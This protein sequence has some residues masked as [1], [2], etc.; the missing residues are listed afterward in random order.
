MKKFISNTVFFIFILI[1]V[2]VYKSIFGDANSLVGIAT[3]VCLLVLMK[4][5]LI[6][7]P[8]YNLNCLLALFLSLGILSYL[9]NL[10]IYLE[11]LCSF[12]AL[13][14]IG[15][16][17]TY[18]L[19]KNLIVPAGLLYL[20]L[21]FDPVSGKDLALRAAGLVIAPFLIMGFQYLIYR[22]KL[23]L[24][25]EE[26]SLLFYI[27]PNR[28][29]TKEYT[30]FGLHLHLHPTRLAFSLRIGV[31]SAITSLFQRLL[32]DHY[33]I[34][35]G[36]WLVYTIFSL[37]ELYSQ[38]CHIKSKQR[39]VGTLI[40]SVIIF[41]LFSIF[42]APSTRSLICLLVGYLNT[43]I[44]NYRDSSILVTISA[45]ATTTLT[46]DPGLVIFYRI[47]FVCIGTLIALIGDHLLFPQKEP[48]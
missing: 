12:I 14:S 1:F 23:L 43:Y 41:V 13:S 8:L 37:T 15:Y 38:N 20:F 25:T 27:R 28:D 48:A 17:L 4:T 9:A 26:S 35:E 46:S 7:K 18:N 32:L 19:S 24:E 2:A 36:R 6:A 30:F 44:S 40:G 47:L 5:N 29:Q 21:L 16:L 3:L 34:P 11:F 45:V 10:N 42:K 39:L 33:H 31:L 22:K